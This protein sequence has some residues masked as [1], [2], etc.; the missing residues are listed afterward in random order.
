M[1]QVNVTIIGLQQLGLSLGLALKRLSRV[2]NAQHTFTITGSDEEVDTLK[3]ARTMGA[4]DLDLRDPADSVAKADLVF[5]TS[6]YALTKDLFSVVGP[7][8][9]PGAVVADFSPLKLP[10]I[11][12]ARDYFRKSKEGKAEAYLVGVTA[13]INPEYLNEM[14]EAAHEDLF[15]NGVFVVSPAPNAPEEA[16]SLIV[17]LADLMGVKVHFTDPTEHDGITAAMEGLP[18]L[19]QVILFRSLHGSPSWDDLQRLGNP[20]FGLATFRLSRDA[21]D[22]LAALV[23]NN[24]GNTVRVL[25]SVSGTIEAMLDLIRNSDEETLSEA[26]SDTAEGYNRWLNARRKNKWREDESQQE[27]QRPNLLGPL[28]G[29][30]LRF[31]RKP[32]ADDQSTKK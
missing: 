30:A 10:S 27:I 9:K 12:W 29:N 15:D 32:P 19:L 14:E 22:N 16:I 23:A 2:P 4:I 6:P 11:A 13:V 26:F 1:A 7:A 21:P 31:G 18:Q 20:A 8:L 25:E 28:F 5:M 3:T 17:D 24:R